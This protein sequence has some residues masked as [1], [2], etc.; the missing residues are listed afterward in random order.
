MAPSGCSSSSGEIGPEATALGWSEFP[1]G[2]PGS[3]I[4]GSLPVLLKD[5]A[6]S[7][8]LLGKY[9]TPRGVSLEREQARVA[10]QSGQRD[11]HQKGEQ[12]NLARARIMEPVEAHET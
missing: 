1:T 5:A 8:Q 9:G 2:W 4:C 7:V 6:P 3:D 11:S 12:L 10:Y